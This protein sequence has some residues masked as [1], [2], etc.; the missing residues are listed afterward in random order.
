MIP[1]F[2][3]L[4]AE[5]ASHFGRCMVRVLSDPGKEM[6]ALLMELFEGVIERFS[7]A[8]MTALPEETPTKVFWRFHFMIGTMA[9]TLGMG[10][11][12]EEY[13]GGASDMQDV[14]EVSERLVRFVTAGMAAAKEPT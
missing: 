14:D 6:R 5:R 13:S 7:T 1:P 4:S 8:L 2:Q 10:H 11:L 3:V 9:Y 12:V